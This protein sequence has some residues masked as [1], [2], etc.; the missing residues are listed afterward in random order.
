MHFMNPQCNQIGG[1]MVNMLGL[2]EVDKGF[3]AWWKIR[4]SRPDGRE[5]G[6]RPDGR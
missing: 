1:V 5:G 4:G 6:S 3:K 2:S